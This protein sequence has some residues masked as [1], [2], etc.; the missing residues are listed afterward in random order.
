MNE[1][2]EKYAFA[3]NA[4]EQVK[5][6]LTDLVFQRI[7]SDKTLMTEYLHRVSESDWGSVNRKIGEMVKK[8]FGLSN[9]RR[10]DSPNSKLILSYTQFS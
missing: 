8:S 10:D 2:N 4:I 5:A 7:E 3:Q 9:L 1:V 6:E